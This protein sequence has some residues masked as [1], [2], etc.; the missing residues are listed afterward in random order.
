MI[1]STPKQQ[2][3]SIQLAFKLLNNQQY[4]ELFDKI[5]DNYLYWDKV[6]YLSPDGIRPEV[7]WN[8]VKIRR[9]T[10]VIN[11]KFGK[12]IFHFTITKRMQAS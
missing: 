11:L 5:D 7:L 6:K 12:Y 3:T 9:S 2:N 4:K 1:E 8:A 10:N